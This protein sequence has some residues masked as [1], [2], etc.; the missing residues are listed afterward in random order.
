MA[1]AVRLKLRDAATPDIG[2]AYHVS[3]TQHLPIWPSQQHSFVN[4]RELNNTI[5][6]NWLLS[7]CNSANNAWLYSIDRNKPRHIFEAAA[8]EYAPTRFTIHG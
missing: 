7:N 1:S 2:S 6:S 3:L 5:D 4:A 8:R